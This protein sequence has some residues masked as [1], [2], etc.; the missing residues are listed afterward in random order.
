MNRLAACVTGGKVSHVEVRFPDGLSCGIYNEETVFLKKRSYSN[1]QY[2]QCASLCA[3][4]D[5]VSDLGLKRQRL[6]R[7]QYQRVEKSRRANAEIRAGAGGQGVQQERHV[8][9]ELATSLAPKRRGSA[10]RHLVLFRADH[11]YIAGRGLDLA[12]RPRFRLPRFPARAV[13][14]PGRAARLA[15]RQPVQ[16]LHQPAGARRQYEPWADEVT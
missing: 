6:R 7:R 2:L 8:Q 9:G 11:R 3:V 4:F 15:H 14:R 12:V 13:R 1:P 16:A 10:P 5:K